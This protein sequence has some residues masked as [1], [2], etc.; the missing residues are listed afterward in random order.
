[1][2][3]PIVESKIREGPLP[4]GEAMCQVNGVLVV[5]KGDGEGEGVT[6][7]FILILAHAVIPNMIWSLE[8]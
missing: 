1:M 4:V 3:H 8:V 2:G 5:R 7:L 6:H